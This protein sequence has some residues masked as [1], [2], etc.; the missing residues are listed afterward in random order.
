[1]SELKTPAAKA[2]RSLLLSL[3]VLALCSNFELA[4]AQ[5]TPLNVA[6]GVAADFL[7][8]FVA[9]DEGIFEKNGLTVTLT[10]FPNTTVIVPAIVSG[11]ISI[12]ASTLP[13][14]ILGGQAGLDL[15]AISGA[16]RLQKSNPRTQLVTRNGLTVASA[17]DLVG[18]RVG[19]PGINSLFDVYLRKWLLADGVRLNQVTIAEVPFAAMGDLLKTGQLDAAVVVEPL[20]GR[21]LSSGAGTGS[22]DFISEVN[23]D[24]LGALWSST[25][26]W[27]NQNASTVRSFQKSLAEGLDYIGQKPERAREIESKYLNFN[28]RTLPSFS[29]DVKPADFEAVIKVTAELGLL[30][31]AVRADKLIWAQP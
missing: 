3:G 22:I 9:K 21:I 29:L 14:I 1:M 25:R 12:G 20:L 8:A 5:T 10:R 17:K 26:S 30:S 11:N 24:L 19:V 18:K 28:A 23:P 6:Y 4:A 16:S 7:P 27:A 2:L 31:E 13:N 15:V